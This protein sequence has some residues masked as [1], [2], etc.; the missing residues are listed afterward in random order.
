MADLDQW[1]DR[2]VRDGY[3]RCR[4]RPLMTEEGGRSTPLGNGY[5]ACWDI[6][7]VF[8]GRPTLNDAPILFEEGEWLALGDEVTVRLHP[9]VWDFWADVKPGQIISA[10]E[11]SR[12]IGLATVL[13]RVGPADA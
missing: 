1:R 12:R 10:Y 2:E 4:F 6:G 11:G 9:L 8:E 13:E 3:F 7:A 5:R